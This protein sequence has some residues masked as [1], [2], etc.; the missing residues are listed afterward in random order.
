MPEADS[1]EY[2][3]VLDPEW[4]AIV[5]SWSWKRMGPYEWQKMGECPYCKHDMT[6][7]RR[8]MIYH[9]LGG[10]AWPDVSTFRG[11]LPHMTDVRCSCKVPHSQS[12]TDGCGRY[13][14]I[15]FRSAI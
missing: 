9:A 3:E 8:L 10:H 6:I 11:L 13:G 7:A 15:P 4:L 14:R 5:S 12:S 1:V 2:E